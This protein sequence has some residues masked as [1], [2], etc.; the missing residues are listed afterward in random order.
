M[1]QFYIFVLEPPVLSSGLSLALT[2]MQP[3]TSLPRPVVRTPPSSAV[4][5]GSIP[6]RGAKTPHALQPKNQKRKT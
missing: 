3:A 2:N 1:F 6:G 4:D 5:V